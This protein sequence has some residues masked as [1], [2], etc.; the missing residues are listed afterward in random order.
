MA[1]LVSLVGSTH[2]PWYHAKVTA[3]DDQLSDDGRDLRRWSER[4]QAAIAKAQPDVIV[5]LAS[6]HFHQFFHHNMPQWI[7]GRMD[8]YEGTFYNEVREFDL[9][10]VKLG[11]DRQLS[12]DLIEAGFELGFDFAVSDE[13]RLD[14]ACVVP[15]LIA[16]PSLD[17]P[18]VPVLTNCGAPP[19]PTGQ[20]F[21]QLGQALRTAIEGSNAV[22]RVCVLASGNLSL[23]VGGP[24]QMMPYPVDPEFDDIAMKWLKERDFERLAS[25][26]TYERLMTHGNTSFQFLNL[27]SMAAMQGDMQVVYA[28]AVKRRG[29][30]KPCFI[31]EPG[32]QQ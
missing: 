15:S 13:L 20:R 16:Q 21:V 11:G 31:Y 1:E 6:D 24:E 30:S 3:P 12:T 4:V 22:Q 9:P 8:S 23:E 28:E 32:G 5:I 14:H 2:H 17:I 18:V 25:E 26:A 7:I 29:S 27:I 19:I 10:R